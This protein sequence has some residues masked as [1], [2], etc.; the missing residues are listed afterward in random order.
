M[1]G[2]ARKSPG[3]SS[4]ARLLGDKLD[5]VTPLRQES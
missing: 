5:E 3:R 1:F 2:L 4:C